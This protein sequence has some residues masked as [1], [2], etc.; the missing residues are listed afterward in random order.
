ME[1]LPAELVAAMARQNGYVLAALLL[2]LAV[3]NQ[4]EKLGTAIQARAE[5]TKTRAAESLN[6]KLVE[7]L[8]KAMGPIMERAVDDR[9]KEMP[10]FMREKIAAI[11]TDRLEW[12]KNE[13]ISQRNQLNDLDEKLGDVAGMVKRIEGKLDK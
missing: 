10:E 13:L 7:A 1:S 12:T 9:I 4:R 11:V 5:S 6:G 8:G 2:A 3:Y